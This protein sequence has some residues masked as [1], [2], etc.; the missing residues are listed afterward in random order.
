MAPRQQFCG[1]PCATVIAGLLVFGL[2]ACGEKSPPEPP[3]KPVAPMTQPAPQAA[4]RSDEARMA[5]MQP[6]AAPSVNPDAEL[7]SRV[8]AALGSDG[9]VNV[10]R[11]DV[12]SEGGV[13]T[14]YGTA[15][16]ADQRAKAGEIA[17][18]VAGVRSVQN[19]LAI[20]AGS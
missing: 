17:A 1:S 10:H 8:K 20:V 13:V 5:T 19:K 12:T 4:P 3:P 9:S 15:E 6:P 14:L 7:A 11:I 16:N 18:A 2:A